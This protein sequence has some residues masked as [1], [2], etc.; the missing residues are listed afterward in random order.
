M[1][2]QQQWNWSGT[3]RYRA[4][5]VV[6]PASIGE[7]SEV[8]SRSSRVRALGTRHSFNDIADTD[9]VLLSVTAIDPDVEVDAASRTVTVGAGSRYGVV[10][11]AL[12]AQ[13]WALHNM[14]S[15]PHISVGGAISTSTHG[16]GDNNGSLAT[17]VRALEFVTS[18]GRLRRVERGEGVFHG[19][20]VALGA[21]GILVRVTLDI[22]PSFLVRQD[23]YRGI[24]WDDFL[25]DVRRVT[26]AGYS[27]SVFTNWEGPQVGHVWVKR[28][29]TDADDPVPDELLGAPRT[30]DVSS[31][32]GE[33][34]LTAFGSTG[35]WLD[36]LPHFRPESTP[37]VGDE[38][39]TEYF[40]ALD[41]AA[42]AL[43]A[44][45]PLGA[46][47]R[48]HLVGSELRTIAADKL[49]LSP[50]YRRDSLGI[51]FT[52]R[53]HPSEVTALIPQIE[54][55]LRPFGARPHWGKLHSMSAATLRP[56]YERLD[57]AR[58]LFLRE[59]PER[60]FW[61]RHLDLV[62]GSD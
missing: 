19:A 35:R 50:A 20:V 56:L 40:V 21:M 25:Y 5:D 59:D 32:A 51:H 33:P 52:W 12:Q 3:Y 14:G 49:W 58:D 48:A 37:S 26:G 31:L 23:E 43:S 10:A 34:N 13:G 18:D 60:K 46:A 55:A 42:D 15:L 53:N 2:A 44:L 57:D 47:M 38:I 28:R 41:D 54:A 45:R 39:Q 29:A 1:T 61:A 62:L 9:G 4:S 7:V 36:R 11:R 16:S 27:V 24:E 30:R 17:A 22:E 6:Y 8:V